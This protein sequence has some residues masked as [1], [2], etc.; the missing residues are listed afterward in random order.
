[1]INNLLK[2]IPLFVLFGLSAQEKAM[3]TIYFEFDKHS[4]NKSQEETIITLINDPENSQFDAVQL[5]GYCDDRGK[6]NYNVRLSNNR[7]QSVLKILLHNGIAASKIY[8]KI[9][10]G[11][12]LIDKDTVRDLQT[13]R[14]KN[15]R[16]DLIFLKNKAQSHFPSSPMVGDRIVLE[17][18]LFDMGSS[19]LTLKTK[20]EL[21][22]IVTL[23]QKFK[24]LQFEIKGYVCCTS[25]KYPDAIDED[26]QNRNLSVNRARNVFVFLRS[27]GISPYRMVY[28]GYGNRVPLGKGDE[29]DRRVEFLITKL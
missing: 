8:K 9:G 6:N 27:K 11:R 19:T 22:Q 5:F 12:V 13:T 3:Q 18:I 28:K 20:N 23:L 2:I 25:I 7:V 26:T 14:D 21:E 4:L 24:T 16:V 10:Y 15:R 1:M 17:R 29:F